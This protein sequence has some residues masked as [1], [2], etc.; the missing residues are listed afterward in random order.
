VIEIERNESESSLADHLLVLDKYYHKLIFHRV[1]NVIV[2]YF[3]CFNSLSVPFC[4]EQVWLRFYELLLLSNCDFEL[5]L[6]QDRHGNC[7]NTFFADIDGRNA[8]QPDRRLH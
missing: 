3:Q 8:E 6:Q 5:W 7:I 4:D 2:T 1:P